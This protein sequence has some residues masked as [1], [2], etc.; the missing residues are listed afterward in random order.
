MAKDNFQEWLEELKFKTNIVNVI[1]RS[2]PL[3]QK[4][5]NLWGLCPFHREKTSSFSV[6]PDGQ[7]YHCFGC[8]A[9]GDVIKFVQ[10]YESVDFMDAV[11]LLA[12]QAGMQVPEFKGGG[13]NKDSK[14]DKDKLYNLMR[15]TANYY[16]SNLLRPQATEAN[17]YV[18]RRGM[19]PDDVKKFGIGFSTNFNDL[20]THLFSKGYTSE[21]MYEA[22]VAD[23][24]EGRYYDCLGGRLIFPICDVMGRPIAFGGRLL[25]KKDFAKYKNTRETKLFVKNRTLYGMHLVKE[26]NKRQKVEDIII[27]EGYMDAISLHKAG[28]NNT[29]ASM[30]TSLTKEQAR[31]LKRQVNRVYISYDGDGAGQKATIRGLDILSAEGLD[32]RVVTLPDDLDPDDTIK[33][34]GAEAYRA[35]INA[36]LPLTEYKLKLLGKHHDLNTVEGRGKYATAAIELLATISGELEREAYLQYVSDKSRLPVPSL[37]AKLDNH[38]NGKNMGETT[39]LPKKTTEKRYSAY[40]LAEKYILNAMLYDKAY[41]G[42]EDLLPFLSSYSARAIYQYAAGLKSEKRHVIPADVLSIV[43][44]EDR[45]EALTVLDFPG[46]PAPEA[47]LKYYRDCVTLLKREYYSAQC[48]DLL[49]KAKECTDPEERK[50][51]LNTISS[52]KQKMKQ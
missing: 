19:T 39:V 32:V 11:K 17:A 6:N 21:Q 45:E 38:L 20:I 35:L 31:I 43:P 37:K 16:F 7:Y 23:I 25:E 46:M 47:E 30:G 5:R 8:G 51:L 36:A 10:E 14:D 40:Q 22:G 44:E 24:S 41:A 15:D 28:F 33:E 12:E 3:Q 13:D 27:V 50:H 52:I 18:A 49:D 48:R 9:S 29:V 26:L 1:S 4:G 34:Q 42:G 2:I